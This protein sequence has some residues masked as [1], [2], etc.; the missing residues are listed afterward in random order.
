M[1][2]SL[3]PKGSHQGYGSILL[4]ILLKISK[5]KGIKEVYGWLFYDSERERSILQFRDEKEPINFGSF[6]LNYQSSLHHLLT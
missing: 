6:L 2:Y 5:E 1:C 3:V 4:K